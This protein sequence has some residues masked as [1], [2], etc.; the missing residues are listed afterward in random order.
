MLWLG[1]ILLVMAVLTALVCNWLIA[2]NAE[3]KCFSSV[4]QIPHRRVGVVL[5]TS[6]TY[7]NGMVNLFFTHRIEAAASL[8]FAGKVDYLLLSGDNNKREYNEPELMKEALMAKGVPERAIYLDYAGL[9]TLD[10]MVRA[11]EV[12]GQDSITVVSQRFHNERA[13]YLAEHVGLEVVAFDAEDVDGYHGTKV[14]LREYMARVKMFLDLLLGK[15][16]KF[17][18]ERIEI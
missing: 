11:K 16:P 4:Q 6:P 14:L 8:F 9:R 1:L 17:L 15:G 7:K 12:F 2:H 10:S 18:G 3:G 13:I 5:G